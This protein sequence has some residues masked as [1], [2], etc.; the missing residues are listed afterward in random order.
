MID[1][2]G[3]MEKTGE[4]I[5]VDA[6]T[7]LLNEGD[8]AKKM[9]VVKKGIL[10]LFLYDSQGRDITFQFFFEGDTVAS[11]NSMYYKEPSLFN[12]ES[13]EPSELIAVEVDDLL[14]LKNSSAETREVFDQHIVERFRKYQLL[15]LSRIK[16]TPQEL[17]EDLC[18]QYPDLIQR[19]PQHYIASYL[20]IT[21]VS[22]SRIRRRRN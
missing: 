6:K 8:V 18:R 2:E 15:F 11:F 20:G 12:L 1:I 5:S 7:I 10:R 17:Y 21:P 13:I 22:L 16:N 19:V 9:Y 14:K 3:W 4:R